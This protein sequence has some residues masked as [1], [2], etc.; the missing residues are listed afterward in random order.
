[1][2]TYTLLNNISVTNFECFYLTLNS[3]ELIRSVPE[4]HRVL[5]QVHDICQCPQRNKS[6]ILWF[7]FGQSGK[8]DSDPLRSGLCVNKM[9]FVWELRC[10]HCV[11]SCL[12]L[13]P[14]ACDPLPQMPAGAVGLNIVM[15]TMICD[16]EALTV[17][18]NEQPAA[19]S[20]AARW[21][22]GATGAVCGQIPTVV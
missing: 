14:A 1:M 11:C 22:L 9:M 17:S 19:R 18:D 8:K 16:S 7:K 2:S 13:H 6:S 10:I 20:G 4:N 21:K 12:C 5:F 3:A 15:V